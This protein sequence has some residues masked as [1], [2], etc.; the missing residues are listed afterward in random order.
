MCCL[1]VM[2]PENVSEETIFEMSQEQ[3]LVPDRKRA[4]LFIPGGGDGMC[5]GPGVG[6]RKRRAALVAGRR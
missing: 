1:E 2:D 3:L 4:R 6:M 5:K